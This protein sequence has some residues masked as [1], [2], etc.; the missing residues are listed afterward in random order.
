MPVLCLI[1]HISIFTKVSLLPGA[2]SKKRP[3]MHIPTNGLAGIAIWPTLQ[4]MPSTPPPPPPPKGP[5]Y[6]PPLTWLD[7]SLATWREQITTRDT[8]L[9]RRPVTNWNVKQDVSSTKPRI[10]HWEYASACQRER[11]PLE[12]IEQRNSLT[13]ARSGNGTRFCRKRSAYCSNLLI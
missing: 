4:D 10:Y 1:V 12:A 8:K 5:N 9:A 7:M 6:W 2:F 13:A 11:P 3:S